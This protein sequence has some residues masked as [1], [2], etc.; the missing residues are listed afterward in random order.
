MTI[1]CSVLNPTVNETLG[2]INYLLADKTGTLTEKAMTFDQLVIG[3][4]VF[5]HKRPSKKDI[6][7]I[8]FDRAFEEILHDQGF[9]GEKARNAMRCLTL[10]HSVL[11][12][13]SVTMY[14]SSPEDMEFLEFAKTYKYVYQVPE[15]VDSHN[16]LVVNELGV[17]QKYRLLE[18]FDFTP[19]RRRHSVIVST[20]IHG[21]EVIMMFTKGADD[22]IRPLLNLAASG[23]VEAVEEQIERLSHKGLRLLMISVKKL[24]KKKWAAFHAEYRQL[25]EHTND[26]D[27]LYR[28]QSEWEQ[29]LELLG[30]VSFQERLQEKVEESLKFMRAAK[31]R[32]WVATGDMLNTA[33]AVARRAGLIQSNSLIL[34]FKDKEKIREDV[35]VGMDAKLRKMPKGAFATCLVDGPYLS[36]IM[37]FKRTNVILYEEFVDIVMRAEVAVF[38]RTYP[39][40]KEQIVQMI[41]ESD[42][43]ALVAAVGDAYNDAYMLRTADV[44]V[45]IKEH[46]HSQVAKISDFAVADFKAV[47]P[48]F[49]YF[50]REAY[51]KNAIFVLFNIYK[52]FLIVLPQFWNGFIN[53]FSGF[54]LYDELAFQLYHVLYTLVPVVLFVVFDKVY[55][56][57]KLLFSPLLYQTGVD[58]FY[59]QPGGMLEN[60]LTGVVL[61]A[62]L[63]LTAFALF[64]WGNYRNGWSYGFYNYGNMC[65][66]GCVV[67]VNL[68]VFVIAS[69]Y[70]IY[71]VLAVLISIGLFVGT[72]FYSSMSASN[73]LYQTF[74]EV[75]VSPQFILYNIV[76]VGVVMLEYII[77]RV[78]YFS[79]EHK[80]VP[81]FDLKF[82]ANADNQNSAAETELA[83]SGVSD[84]QEVD[85]VTNENATKK[86]KRKTSQSKRR[87]TAL[88]RDS[89]EDKTRYRPLGGKEGEPELAPDNKKLI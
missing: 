6:R 23:E 51:R 17:L 56:K 31:I 55:S 66:Y 37:D 9:E 60:Q 74:W 42:E 44:G 10:C 36:Q 81:D 50:G 59:L 28:K 75:V 63:T 41:K 43:R 83:I 27:Q 15:Q 71:Q 89:V 29:E 64:D 20:E 48:L 80:Y 72:W 34:R 30:V 73:A 49:F 4:Y 53:F 78:A 82:D 67:L 79:F 8:E 84:N 19:E 1:G 12:D 2:Q 47:V 65:I 24:D 68:K 5:F 18:R 22:A 38:A 3:R 35:F 58:N 77:N 14:S 62:L 85:L 25:K 13:D 16:F 39:Q 21:K 69:S 11:F 45:A 32:T 54:P 87:S 57:S 70:S 52:N 26:I 61:S 86:L 7:E 88:N 33:T 40:Q 76:L 46:D